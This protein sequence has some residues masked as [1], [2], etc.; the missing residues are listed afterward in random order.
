[1][2]ICILGMGECTTENISETS[3]ITSNDTN[4]DNS[5]KNQINQDCNQLMTQ[6]NTINIVGSTVKKLSASQKNSIQSMCIMQSILKS[7][8]SADVVNKLLDKVKNNLETKGAVFGSPASNKTIVNNM[9]TNKT[10]INNSKFNEIS[11]K[12]IMDIKQSNLLNI[13]GSNVE[14]TTTDQANEAFL[15]CLSQHSDD[16][17]ISAASLSDTKQDAD[18]TSKAAGG[19]LGE[20]I[21]AAAEGVGKGVG[22]AAEGVGAGVGKGL[23]GVISAYMT[24]I[25]IICAIFV[26]SSLAALG[27]M[28]MKPDATAQLAQSA[29]STASSFRQMP[30]GGTS[31]MY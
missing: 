19:D 22:A 3:N 18:N 11:K 6:S 27:F 21:G 13:I 24:P 12:C 8:T 20:S 31:G 29:A 7:N 10:N 30:M 23:G 5:I 16:T 2:G 25:I 28:L 9:T 15:K 17:G 26:F 4:I 1:M 14:D